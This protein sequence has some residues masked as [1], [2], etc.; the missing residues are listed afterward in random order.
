MYKTVYCILSGIKYF[1]FFMC[2]NLT[3]IE[4][5]SSWCNGYST[6]LQIRTKRV[7]PPIAL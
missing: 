1:W 3:Y 2:V 4:G 7:Q 6:E 5:V